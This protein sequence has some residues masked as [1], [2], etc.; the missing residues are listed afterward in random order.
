MTDCSTEYGIAVSNMQVCWAG[1]RTVHASAGQAD[2]HRFEPTL[3]AGCDTS[4]SLN[5]ALPS[6]VSTMPVHAGVLQS[7]EPWSMVQ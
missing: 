5:I 7:H 6:L 3:A 2:Q 1:K 4:I